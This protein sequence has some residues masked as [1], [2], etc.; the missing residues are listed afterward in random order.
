M[1]ASRFCRRAR[2]ATLASALMLAFGV[3]GA[4]AQGPAGHHGGGPQGDMLAHVLQE[5]KAGLNLNTSQQ[6]MWDAA[7]AQSKAA[8]D[9]GHA[10]HQRT[11]SALDA[12]LAKAEPDLAAVATV[13]D[14]AEVQGRALRHSVRDQWLRVYA[15]FSP[16]Q[17][18][19]VRDAIKQRVA[20][21][22][23]FRNRMHEKR[24]PNR[25]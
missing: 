10:L 18:A 2:A 5:M 21:F 24:G 1:I 12:E 22:D 14:D 6:T 11:K 19:V 7:V 17:K 25:G 4:A 23:E 20:R 16:T 8:R 9:Q 13:A 3:T 15:T